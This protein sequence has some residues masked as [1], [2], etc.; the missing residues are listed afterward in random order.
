MNWLGL[1]R[2]HSRFAGRPMHRG[3][4]RTIAIETARVSV[5]NAARPSNCRAKDCDQAA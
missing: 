3:H 1:M 5:D 4:T 2:T